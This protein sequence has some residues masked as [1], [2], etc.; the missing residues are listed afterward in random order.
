[1]RLFALLTLLSLTSILTAQVTTLMPLPKLAEARKTGFR[2]GPDFALLTSTPA[3]TRL[4]AAALRLIDRIATRTGLI[5]KRELWTGRGMP[6]AYMSISGGEA[7]VLAPG[8]DESYKLIVAENNILLEAATDVGALRGMETLMQLLDVDSTGWYFHGAYIQDAPRFTWRG[9]LIDVCRHWQPKEVIF[10][11]LDAM[12]MVKMNVLHLHLSEDQ[13]F[14]IESKT[15]PKLHEQGSGGNYFTQQDIRDIIAYADARGIRVVPEFDLPGHATS[16]FVGYPELASAPGPYTIE[17]NFGVFDPTFDPTQETTYTF[18]EQFLAEMCALFPDPY[19]HIGGD[20][21]NGKQWNENPRIQSYMNDHGLRDNH[22][23]QC[24]FNQ[25]ISKFLTAGGKKM[26]GWDEILQPELPNNIMIQSWRGKEAMVEAA[27]KG[28][29][30]ILSN[31]WYIDL[32]QGTDYHYSNEPIADPAAYKG[33]AIRHVLGGEATM[34]AELVTPETID[35]RIWPRTAAIAERLWSPREATDLNSMYAR[36]AITSI[37]LESVGCQHLTNPARMLRRLTGKDY[38]PWTLLTRYVS[39]LQGYARHSQG[40]HYSVDL[41]LTRLP[42]IAVPD[43]DEARRFNTAARQFMSDDKN[44]ELISNLRAVMQSWV[45][46]DALIRSM[47][48]PA[49]EAG[50]LTLS[51][52][53]ASLGRL[54]IE[55]LDA[56]EAYRLPDQAWFDAAN[57]LVEEAKK[58]VLECELVIIPG[59]NDLLRSFKVRR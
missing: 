33:D 40:I 55:A 38:T 57:K 56:R 17:K 14:R 44:A 7:A 39:P 5:L 19:F 11:N 27:N 59:I 28:Y 2:L 12:A 26:M 34:W 42:D 32:C 4:D 20:E 45:Q 21:N 58:P 46:R 30:V 1:M 24:Y 50:W 25:R 18:L 31:G 54:G 53:L 43:P 29:D 41:P 8:M 6:A 22:A 35:S 3:G 47:E 9:L 36:L 37:R 13:G 10:R 52:R 51:G 16:W 49:P 23:L 15:F 48:E